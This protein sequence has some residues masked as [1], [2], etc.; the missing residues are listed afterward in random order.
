M[1]KGFDRFMQNPYY[2]EQYD[3]APSEELKKYYRLTWDASPFVEDSD[4]DHE[5]VSEELKK[6]RLKK[7]DVEYLAKYAVGGAEKAMLKRWLS[8]LS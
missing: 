2:K 4:V 1:G 5:K 8:Q 6:I 3:G 7:S